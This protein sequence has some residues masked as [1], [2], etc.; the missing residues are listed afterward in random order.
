MP[1][2]TTV[3]LDRG[4]VAPS[5]YADAPHLVTEQAL[6]L[7][8]ETRNELHRFMTQYVRFL[9]FRGVRM[10]Y[11][12]DLYFDQDRVYV[13]EVNVELADGWGV[14]LNLLRAA[15][16]EFEFDGWL[17]KRFPTF[18]DDP[19]QTEF[20]LAISEFGLLNHQAELDFHPA[21]IVEVCDNKLYLAKFAET[22]RGERVLVPKIYW[23]GTSDWV[24]VPADVYL[25]FANK[26]S[27]EA[28]KSRYSAKPRS[29]LGRARQMQR[30]FQDG[31]AIAQQQVSPALTAS[32][33]VVQAVVM[34]YGPKPITGYIQLADPERQV[35][36]DK[37]T[38]KGPLI[39][40]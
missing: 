1:K 6:L 18:P 35:I 19:R 36:N 3:T 24:D 2:L 5:I 25:K 9:G 21:R 33:E 23:H 10:G 4:L 12:L 28:V 34:C 17:P 32:G 26:F 29:E 22:W 20:Q 40:L 7:D 30:L 14:S 31:K 13:I 15:Q 11:R 16:A 8:S 27:P 39:F 37:G 38:K